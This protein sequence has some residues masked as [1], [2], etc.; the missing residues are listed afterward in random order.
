MRIR[1]VLT[2]L[3]LVAS[4][5]AATAAPAGAQ[6]LTCDDLPATIVGTTGNDVLRGTDGPDVIVALGGNDTIFGGGGGDTICGGLGNDTIRGQ[7]GNDYIIGGSGSDLIFG[8]AGGDTIFGLDGSDI[9]WGGVGPDVIH[10]GPGDD[11]IKAGHGNDVAVGGLGNDVI[12]GSTGADGL[13]GGG[14]AD[15]LVGGIGFDELLGG[16][17]GDLLIGG[18]GD[19]ILRAGNGRNQC[20]VDHRDTYTRC[21]SGT[22]NGEWGQGFG[23]FRV[24]LSD[25]F[26][27]EATGAF[28]VLNVNAVP[29]GDNG[30]LFRVT[31]RDA[32][33]NVLLDAEFAGATAHN[34]LVEGQPAEVEIL[35]AAEWSLAFVAERSIA[36]NQQFHV[37][38]SDDVF[39][40]PVSRDGQGQATTV[41]V[42]NIGTQPEPI[43]IVSVG[44][45]GI[46][47]E[48]DDVIQPGEDLFVGDTRG[49]ARY[50]AFFGSKDLVWGWSL[51]EFFPNAAN[52]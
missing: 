32:N 2:S 25:D 46:T 21:T 9:L 5:L 42:T 51:D 35:G 45:I 8:N 48:L 22:V 7:Q 30:D 19:D 23:R 29:S 28:H 49:S 6:Q 18:G 27:L 11:T 1:L 20:R 41:Q 10:G 4:T 15:Q 12:E 33:R 47:V 3:A 52:T 24:D 34:V 17:G 26:A 13:V 16:D 44:A 36:Q 14:G 38:N 31:V 50:I 40:I 37:G 39:A 43:V